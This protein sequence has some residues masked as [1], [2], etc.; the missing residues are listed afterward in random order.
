MSLTPRIDK[1]DS[2][3]LINGNFRFW[4][5]ALSAAAPGYCSDRWSGVSGVNS[6]SRQTNTSGTNSLYMMQVGGT[7]GDIG[8]GQ[9]VDAYDWDCVVVEYSNGAYIAHLDAE[10]EEAKDEVLW[11][12]VRQERS[13]RL[14]ECDWTQLADA[15]LNS[16]DKTA[17]AEYRQ[18]LGRN[19][20][21]R[22][23]ISLKRMKTLERSNGLHSLMC[24]FKVTHA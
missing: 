8:I 13:R 19:I 12:Q 14:A 16:Q 4:Q 15:P 24:R 1:I 11:I 17:W 20:A 9:R 3:I 2:N 6:Q 5:R 22:F 21:K 23:A 18:A 7:S 10:L